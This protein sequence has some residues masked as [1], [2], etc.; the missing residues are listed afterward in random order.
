MT[1]PQFKEASMGVL[2][3]T[4]AS[5]RFELRRFPPSKPLA[6][7]V[8]H[9]WLVSWD[10]RG[11]AD[12]DQDVIPNPCV[13]LVVEQSRAAVYGVASRKYTKH[14]SGLG[15]AFGIKFHP[16]G[17]YPFLRRPMSQLTDSSISLPDVFGDNGDELRQA[18]QAFAE[19]ELLIKQAEKLLAKRMPE[20]D[21]AVDY[22]NEIIDCIRTN[23]SMTN[24]EELVRLFGS[25]TRKL[26]RLFS[27]YVGVSPKWVIQLYR[28][29]N[30]A[31]SL[32]KGT[33]EDLAKLSVELGFYDQ[34]HFIRAFKSMIGVTP[35][36]YKSFSSPVDSVPS[37][38]V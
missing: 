7:F 23:R 17:F 15:Q 3:T 36:T 11:Q 16:G 25:H 8:K 35:E 24:V 5:K 1:I 13:N 37:V 14:L 18:F 30:A 34:S 27:Q 29:Q 28:L 31:E 6:P 22:I 32:D 26:Q 10:L 9:Y 21:P 38:E 4:E 12:F 19:P 33:Y 2:L 20:P